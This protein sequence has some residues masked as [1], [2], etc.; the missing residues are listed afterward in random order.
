MKQV[1]I[2]GASGFGGEIAWVLE[3]MIA[4]SGGA[5]VIGFC[6]DAPGK[7]SGVWRGRPLLGP[8]GAAACAAG[9]GGEVWFHVAVGSNAARERL[10]ARAIACG[11][12]PLTVCD[13]TALVAA[14]ARVGEGCYIGAGAVVSCGTRIGEGVIINHQATVGH[15]AVVD[16]FA[17]I[18]PGARVSGG[19]HIG[20]RALLGSNAVVIPGVSVGVDATVGATAAALRDVPGGGGVARV[21]R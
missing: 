21:G 10:T 18:C 6:D 16:A 9:A 5:T 19:C 20:A 2:I 13:P 3:R 8:V 14:D 11:W 12:R 7:Q 17:Q 1:I 4:P 15:D